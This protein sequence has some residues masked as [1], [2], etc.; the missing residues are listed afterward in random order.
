MPYERDADHEDKPRHQP[1]RAPSWTSE[2]DFPT[3][4]CRPPNH[5]EDANPDGAE[6]SEREG[7]LCPSGHSLSFSLH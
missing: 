7:D 3:G 1:R 2:P 4:C 6:D 5:R